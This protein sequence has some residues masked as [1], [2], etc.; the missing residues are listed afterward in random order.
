MRGGDVPF[1]AEKFLYFKYENDGF[2]CIFG[3]VG[4]KIR[5]PIPPIKK[6]PRFQASITIGQLLS[7][8]IP[9]DLSSPP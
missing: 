3:G 2:W 9:R 4:V 8:Y 1:P 7:T 5:W 6:R